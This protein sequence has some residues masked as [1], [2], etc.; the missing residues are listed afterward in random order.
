MWIWVDVFSAGIEPGTLRITKFLECRAL[1][2]WAM[3]T[4]WI[5]ENPLGP[6]FHEYMPQGCCICLLQHRAYAFWHSGS[7]GLITWRAQCSLVG[8][9][10]SLHDILL[11]AI[12]TSW[13]SLLQQKM[14]PLNVRP[15]YRNSTLRELQFMS[16]HGVLN[17]PD[18]LTLLVSDQ[19][20]NLCHCHFQITLRDWTTSEISFWF[21]VIILHAVSDLFQS[22]YFAILEWR[23]RHAT[24]PACHSIS[25]C[26][27]FDFIH[28]L[29]CCCCAEICEAPAPLVED[30]WLS[31]VDSHG[32]A[33]LCAVGCS[34]GSCSRCPNSSS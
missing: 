14:F 1:H 29:Q 3:V 34:H 24:F 2:H 17:N 5:T 32:C 18:S 8:T 13:I 31:S 27:H 22:T 6:S 7:A 20:Y 26:V 33:R 11:N 28:Q 10:E 4:G 23:A 25:A 15:T 12:S 16:S 9:S 21:C 30:N 19:K